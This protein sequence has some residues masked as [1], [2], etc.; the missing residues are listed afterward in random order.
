MATVLEQF[1]SNY[2]ATQAEDMGIQE[3]LEIKDVAMAR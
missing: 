1:R 3:Y 2:S